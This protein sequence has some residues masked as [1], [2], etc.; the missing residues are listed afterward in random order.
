[1][2]RSLLIAA[3]FAILAISSPAQNPTITQQ[4]WI[5]T[6]N[7]PQDLNDFGFTMDFSGNLY[8]TGISE[9]S[10]GIYK[11]TTLKYNSEGLLMWSVPYMTPGA[12]PEIDFAN[13]IKVDPSGDNIYIAASVAIGPSGSDKEFT[14]LQY[15]SSGVLQW[16]YVHPDTGEAYALKI[17]SSGIYAVGWTKSGP[18]KSDFTTV[19]LANMPKHEGLQ[20][21]VPG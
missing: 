18:A 7:G 1:M 12:F 10:P 16:E 2:K 17:H 13:D 21:A 3:I 4:D 6:F 11:I 20:G 15:D 9:V 14:V 8:V 19:K 5:S